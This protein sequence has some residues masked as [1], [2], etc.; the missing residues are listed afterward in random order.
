[1]ANKLYD[2][3]SESIKFI[4]LLMESNGVNT[5]ALNKRLGWKQGKLLA[6]LRMR[7]IKSS[8]ERE[9]LN[10]LGYEVKIVKKK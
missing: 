1:M 5:N 4:K 10:E 6:T 8:L 2:N 7:D 3:Q 9:V